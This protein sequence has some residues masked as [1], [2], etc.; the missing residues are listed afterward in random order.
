MP[1]QIS[2]LVSSVQ[3]SILLWMW[4]T[5]TGTIHGVNKSMRVLTVGHVHSNMHTAV[6]EPGLQPSTHHM[7]S[8]M[9]AETWQATS[10]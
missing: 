5:D 10:N 1:N 7:Q 4:S 3:V 8:Y 2:V 6:L 9:A